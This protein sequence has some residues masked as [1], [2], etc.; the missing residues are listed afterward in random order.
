[1][2]RVIARKFSTWFLRSSK[3]RV[4]RATLAYSQNL[5]FALRTAATGIDRRCVGEAP[6][7]SSSHI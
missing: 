6:G 3:S 4:C 5:V 2:I 1:M 7:R